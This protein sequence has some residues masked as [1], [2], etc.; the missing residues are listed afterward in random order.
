MTAADFLAF[1]PQFQSVI[2]EVVLSAY[3]DSA[4][5]RFSDFD[6]DAEEARRL[7][8]AHKLTLYARA[9]PAQADDAHGGSS[10]SY[11][12][13]SAAGDSAKI[14]SKKVDGVAV[15]YASGSSSSAASSSSLAD[16]SETVFGSQLLTLLR[17][18]AYTRYVP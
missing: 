16:L 6:A 5:L 7:F 17:L 15:T 11:S 14:T 8:V 12:S 13:L 4:N 9:V 3:V 10:A 2:P 18:Y 1:Y